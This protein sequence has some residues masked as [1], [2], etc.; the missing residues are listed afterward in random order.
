MSLE[1]LQHHLDLSS[2]N[3]STSSRPGNAFKSSTKVISK[4]GK[5][6]D[7][8]GSGSKSKA[9]NYVDIAALNIEANK[10][11]L[12]DLISKLNPINEKATRKKTISKRG[13]KK[14]MKLN[15]DKSFKPKS[16][17]I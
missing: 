2:R 15:R 14:L 10:K 4:K 8:S 7:S 3:I 13:A 5:T 17:K 16:K 11:K 6:K 1:A 12:D 9:K